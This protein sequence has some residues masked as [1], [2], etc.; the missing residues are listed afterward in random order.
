MLGVQR[1]PPRSGLGIGVA[2]G[3]KDCWKQAVTAPTLD[4]A[5]ALSVDRTWGLPSK[6]G[7]VTR[8]SR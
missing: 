6:T 4:A 8:D 2:V 1:L 3:A 7:R 5:L